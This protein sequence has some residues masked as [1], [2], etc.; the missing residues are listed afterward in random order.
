ML[1]HDISASAK[2]DAV[3]LALTDE[4]HENYLPQKG[5]FQNQNYKE[6]LQHRKL[7]RSM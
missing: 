2:K 6:E 3:L 4:V 5:P 7:K 1:H